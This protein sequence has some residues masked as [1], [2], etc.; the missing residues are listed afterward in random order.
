MKK[1]YRNIIFLMGFKNTGKDTVAQMLNEMSYGKIKRVSFA[2][3]LKKEYYSL[4]GVDESIDVENREF[5]E[6]HRPGIIAYGEGKKQ[7]NGPFYW[8][9]RA[10]DEHLFSEEEDFDI[11]VTDCRRVE[12]VFWYADFTKGIMPKYADIREKFRPHF[13]AIH[14]PGAEKEDNDYLTQNAIRVATTI[15]APD[16]FINNN[17]DLKYLK[18]RVQEI[19]AVRFR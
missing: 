17:K 14:R 2:D 1:A 12:E 5:K 16:R 13:I 9:E 4:V 15:Y 8:I 7:E 19:Y 11:V 6:K 10:L 3:A 18:E